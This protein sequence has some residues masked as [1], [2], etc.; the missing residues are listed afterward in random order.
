LAG[1]RKDAVEYDGGYLESRAAA[2]AFYDCGAAETNP[3]RRDTDELFYAIQ[4][5]Y[6]GGPTKE[7]KAKAYAHALDVLD[8]L[9]ASTKFPEIKQAATEE[10]ADIHVKIDALDTDNPDSGAP[11]NNQNSSA[12]VRRAAPSLRLPALRSLGIPTLKPLALP[13][14]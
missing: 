5:V 6:S 7:G 14:L 2:Q 9:M 13:T 10:E 8:G 3:T 4:L 12:T 1:G 11:S